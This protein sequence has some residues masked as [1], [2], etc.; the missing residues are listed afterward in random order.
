M[1]RR[2]Y[3]DPWVKKAKWLTQA[4]IISGTLNVGLLCTFIYSA[5]KD[6]RRPIS[7]RSYAAKEVDL[8]KTKG[9]QDL[10]ASYST[11]SFQD[12]LLKLAS[13]DHIEA[14]YTRRDIALAC[15]TRFH[16]FNLER[17]LGGGGMEKRE[18]SFTHKEGGETLSLEIFPGLADYQYQAIVKYAKTEKWPLTA[19]GLFF[20]IQSTRP[21]YD[22]SLLEAFYLTGEFHFVHLLFSKTGIGLKKEHLAALLSQCSWSTLEETAEHLRSHNTFSSSERRHFLLTLLSQDSKLAAK[23]LLE[24]DQEYCLKNLDNETVI[25]LCNLLGD[26][27]NALFLKSLLESPRP[28]AVWKKAAAL[29]YEQAAEDIPENL[30]LAASKRRFIELKVDRATPPPPVKKSSSYT[31]VS[32]DS[33]WKIARKHNTTVARLRE[34]NNLRSDTLKVGQSLTIPTD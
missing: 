12:L 10:L 23:I 1:A 8:T 25:R 27:V 28:D 32:G 16:H 21:P 15:L 17:A 34:S 19:K 22:P 13:T 6:S 5:V 30:D 31:V 11:L 24:A 26:R 2:S 14:G 18:I 7:G 33:L 20:K 29:L 9:L 4:L 3:T